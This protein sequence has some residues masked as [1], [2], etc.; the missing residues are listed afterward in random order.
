MEGLDCDVQGLGARRSWRG[1]CFVCWR[2]TR[3][4]WS[5]CGRTVRSL[6]WRGEGPTLD[7]G[8]EEKD[9]LTIGCPRIPVEELSSHSIVNFN[10]SCAA[11]GCSR[12]SQQG[13]L[14]TSFFLICSLFGR[15]GNT[16]ALPS[17]LIDVGGEGSREGNDGE[18]LYW[19]GSCVSARLVLCLDRICWSLESSLM[20]ICCKYIPQ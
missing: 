3:G 1:G 16:P 4:R 13:S 9:D 10:L 20:L 11:M 17:G 18:G 14:H 6:L 8:H 19:R 12:T 7:P 15:D 2:K 5:R